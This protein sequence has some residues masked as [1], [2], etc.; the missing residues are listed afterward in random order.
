MRRSGIL[1]VLAVLLS[2]LTGCQS[3]QTA[4]RTVTVSGE[5]SV[6][7]TPDMASFSVSIEETADTTSQAQSGANAKMA[8]ITSIL[9][10]QYGI[11]A[12]DIRT[13]GMSLYPSY[14][15]QD[16]EQILIGQTASQSLSVT[17]HR[18]DDMAPIVDSLSSVSGISLSSISLDASDKS[19]AQS[20]A[21]RLAVQDALSRATDY[22]EGIGVSV[23]SPIS[24]Q[25]SGSYYA[26]NRIQ[27]TYLAAAAK[28]ED[29]MSSASYYAG[30]LSVSSSV[31]VTFEIQ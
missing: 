14:R 18:L 13:T 7:L 30:D 24:I 11:L 29:A 26:A 6:T 4:F 17:V 12:E 10:G 20:E 15:Y 19:Q 28:A 5:G 31:D 3:S 16:G 2:L 23:V 27:P 25:E 9:E 8:E 1:I 21:R 22:A